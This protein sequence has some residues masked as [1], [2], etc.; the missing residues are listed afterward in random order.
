M[1]ALSP[2]QKAL[3][4]VMANAQASVPKG[5]HKEFLT[6]S[7]FDGVVM[8]LPDGSSNLPLDTTDLD[9]LVEAGLVKV[10]AH[11]DHGDMNGVVTS[12]GFAFLEAEATHSVQSAASGSA[13]ATASAKRS[14]TVFYS[15]QSDIAPGAA[16]RS[17]IEDALVLSAKKVGGDDS[18]GVEAVIDRDTQNV[19]GSPDI[20]TTILAKIESADVFV[21]DVTMVGKTDSGKRTPNPNVLI[22][23]GYALHAMG[24]NRV[25]LVQNTAMGGPEQLPFDLRQKRVLVFNSPP[26]ATDRATER[27]ALAGK[28]EL[29]LREV[30]KGAPSQ[31]QSVELALSSKVRSVDGSVHH[32]ELMGAIANK[33]TKRFDD[34]EV[35]IELPTP[36]M[37][38]SVV[39]G[40]KV[41]KQSDG[42][43]SLFRTGHERLGVPLRVGEQRRVT[44]GYRVDQLMMAPG[45]ELLAQPAQIRAFVDGELVATL[46]RTIEDLLPPEVRSTNAK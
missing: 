31:R 23:L 28:L 38:P 11:R 24:P 3:L 20:G 16:C 12:Q 8:I 19:P 5:G 17:L 44:L 34:W 2:D 15:W 30:V 14:V 27:R 45:N 25:I 21:A 33:G 41:E 9:E 22:E 36:L 1:A 40:I 35:E 42:C 18:I 43:R 26:D 32:C 4:A 46:E 39:V 37:E 29:A 6:A 10:T 7:S 13:N